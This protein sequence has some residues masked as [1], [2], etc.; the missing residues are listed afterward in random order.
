MHLDLVAC[1]RRDTRRILEDLVLHTLRGRLDRRI[2]DVLREEGG[3]F[4]QRLLGRGGL[5]GFLL[6]LHLQKQVLQGGFRG[7]IVQQHRAGGIR[8][9]K[10]GGHKDVHLERDVHVGDSL[11]EVH[12]QSVTITVDRAVKRHLGRLGFRCGRRVHDRGDILA[13]TAGNQGERPQKSSKVL[14]KIHLVPLSKHDFLKSK[15]SKKRCVPSQWGPSRRRKARIENSG[16]TLFYFVLI[17]DGQRFT[18]LENAESAQ[19]SAIFVDKS[20]T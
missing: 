17:H 11:T 12:A 1:L 7:G 4:V 18:C 13:A 9:V 3:L 20:L 10:D 15:I 8:L 16:R 19:I 2:H 6:L 14:G 5:V